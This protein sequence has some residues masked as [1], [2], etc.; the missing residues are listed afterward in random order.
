M[1]LTKDRNTMRAESDERRGPLLAAVAVFA[2]A[3]V[4]R[5]AAGYLTKG[6]TATGL[7]GVGVARERKTGGA[8]N[9]DETLRY[10]PG[11]FWFKNST[12]TD[13]I[14]IAEVGDVCWVVDDEQVAKTSGSTTRSC[15]GWVE[16]VDANLGVLVRFDE[17]LLVGHIAALAS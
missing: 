17:P 9:G 7:V 15:A 1:A 11:S 13:E 2:G 10:W 6:Q 5:N 14:T 8:G 3:I 12:S 4:M 16:A